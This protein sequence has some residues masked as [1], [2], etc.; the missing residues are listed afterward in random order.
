M[1]IS[2][3]ARLIGLGLKLPSLH[4]AGSFMASAR[5]AASFMVAGP[6]HQPPA[7]GGPHRHMATLASQPG[8]QTRCG[9]FKPPLSL[10]CANPYVSIFSSLLP[11][12]YFCPLTPPAPNSLPHALC[13]IS[14][15]H[16]WELLRF[17][18]QRSLLWYEKC[19]HKIM[20]WQLMVSNCQ[21]I[22]LIISTSLWKLTGSWWPQTMDW[23]T[24]VYP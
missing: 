6:S 19:K 18:F 3:P 13:L 24:F 21:L 15:H 10:L 23:L 12:Y 9:S 5:A 8:G 2:S 14:T 4:N 7:E 1:A 17:C 11:G 16:C 20:N 22:V